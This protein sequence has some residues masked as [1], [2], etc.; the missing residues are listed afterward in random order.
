MTEVK[1]MKNNSEGQKQLEKAEAQ[2]EAF[3]K[4]VKSLTLDRMNDA[5]KL[6]Q[7]QQTKVA[8]TDLEKKTHPYIKPFRTIASRE[9]FNE[10]YREDYNFSKEYVCFIAENKEVIG[11]SL[12]FWSKPFPGVPAEEWK[13]P[14]NTPVWAPRYVAEQIKRKTYHKL[15]MQNKTPT[16]IDGFATYT[17][18]IVV[19]NVIQRLDAQPYTTRKS[20]FMGNVGFKAA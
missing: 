4:E 19:D 7:E 18:S 6:D 16:D 11:E 10:K 13:I 12:D 17:G 15:S 14:V 8:Q 5:P 3:D 9:K 2:F 1:K 20:I